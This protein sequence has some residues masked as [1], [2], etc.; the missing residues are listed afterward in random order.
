MARYPRTSR[1]P[2]REDAT[3]P[4]WQPEAPAVDF[5]DVSIVMPCLN[6]AASVATC[7]EKAQRWLASSGR[8]GEVVVVDNGSQDESVENARAA[9]ARV[10]FESR[11]GYGSALRK[12]IT[13]ARG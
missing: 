1:T 4:A 12:G 8:T 2:S 13:S 5:V 3:T 10:V 7:I 11:R 6:E 9:G